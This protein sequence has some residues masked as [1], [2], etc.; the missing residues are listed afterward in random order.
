MKS[1]VGSSVNYHLYTNNVTPTLATVL[2]DF[3]EAAWAGYA[4]INVPVADFTLTGVS[5]HIGSI[6]ALPIAFLN[7][8]VSPVT[9]YGYYITDSTDTFLVGCARFDGAP[10]SIASLASQLVSPTFANFSQLAS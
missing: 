6:T 10:V 7:G 1:M 9:V 8:T 5:A 3:T 4:E 2:G